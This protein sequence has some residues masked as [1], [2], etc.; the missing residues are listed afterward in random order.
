MAELCEQATNSFLVPTAI[1]LPMA[2]LHCWCLSPP[3]RQTY[4]M[5]Q[6]N[7]YAIEQIPEPSGL[8]LL[9]LG[10]T[11][12]LVL[13]RSAACVAQPSVCKARPR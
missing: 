3:A 4:C 8:A 2:S 13:R 9:G 11:G 6:P 5:I 1:L 12:L 10:L 7:F